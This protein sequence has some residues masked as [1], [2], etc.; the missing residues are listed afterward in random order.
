MWRREGGTKGRTAKEE[1]EQSV[2]G[3][4]GSATLERDETG[5]W[6]ARVK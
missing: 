1:K 3:G 2:V 5:G 4:M 6:E